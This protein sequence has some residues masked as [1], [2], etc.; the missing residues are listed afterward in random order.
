MSL[1]TSAQQDAEASAAAAHAGLGF[2]APLVID[3]RL[4]APRGEQFTN[5][6]QQAVQRRQGL[7]DDDDNPWAQPGLGGD[8]D[9]GNDESRRTADTPIESSNIGFKLLQKMG[10]KGKGLGKDETGIVEPVKAGVEAGVRLGLGKQEE[11]DAHTNEATAARKR[12]EIEVAA[13]EDEEASKRREA[14]AETLQKRAE[15]VKEMLQ[16]V[17]RGAGNTPWTAPMRE[18]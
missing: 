8:W 14:V 18:G 2:S 5:A 12:L 16:T 9:D 13:Q 17:G 6:Y 3:P 11:D 15:D 7:D 10:W 4:H 1:Y